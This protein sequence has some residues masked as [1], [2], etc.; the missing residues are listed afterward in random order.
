MQVPQ[1]D[2]VT[3]CAHWGWYDHQYFGH[4]VFEELAGR[5]SVTGLFALSI[6]GRRLPD[7]C[8]DMLDDIA[9]V[10]T[11]ADPRIWPLKMSRIVAAYGGTMPAVAAGCLILQSACIGPW[12][13]EDAAAVLSEL[14]GQIG[15]Q[16][17]NETAVDQALDTLFL[18]TPVISGFGAPFHHHDERLV[19]LRRRVHERGRDRLPHWV[20]MEA[21]ANRVRATR[22]LNPNLGFGLAAALLD[23]G[24]AVAEVGPLCT[25]LCQHMFFANAVEGAKQSP[26][27]LQRIPTSQISYEGRA[28]RLSPKAAAKHPSHTF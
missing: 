25:I 27:V 9:C 26:S 18:R 11:L 24:I 15:D 5:T 22:R 14:H 4:A 16:L 1:L 17:E 28:A 13:T 8:L 3:R 19:A 21:V 20:S 23:I 6:L 12:K 2:L 10:C 7:D